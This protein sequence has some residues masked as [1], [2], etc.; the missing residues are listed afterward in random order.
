MVE[1]KYKI[2]QTVYY[3][4]FGTDSNLYLYEAEIKSIYETSTMATYSFISNIHNTAWTH[5]ESGLFAT[6]AEALSSIKS[7][8]IKGE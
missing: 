8:K 6:E 1:K 4:G 5:S 7:G 3:F 2:G